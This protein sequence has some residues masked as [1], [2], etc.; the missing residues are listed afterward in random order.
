MEEYEHTIGKK[1]E[2]ILEKQNKKNRIHDVLLDE[3][4]MKHES[5]IKN[6]LVIKQLQMKIGQI[7]Q[8]IIGNYLDFTDLGTGDK[9]GLDI[10][11]RKRKI[12][13]EIKNRYNTDNASARK[14]N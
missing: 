2:K 9:T 10:T 1:I 11:N 6:S 13:M 12:I 4:F 7:W 3:Y 8:I 14:T 5:E